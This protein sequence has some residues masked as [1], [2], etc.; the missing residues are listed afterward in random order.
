[1]PRLLFRY[2]AL[3]LVRVIALTTAVL[4][5]VIAFGAAIK[6]LAGN[7]LLDPGQVL[8]Y[9]TL[10]I[11]PMLQF[12]LPFSA[13]FG[14]TL[15]LHRLASD[16]EIQAMALSG[17]SYRRILMPVLALGLGLTLF[18]AVLTQFVIPRFWTAIEGMLAEDAIKL[19][20]SS[21]RRNEPF[22][23]GEDKNLQIYADEIIVDEQ[24]SGADGRD[25]RLILIKVAAAALDEQRRIVRDITANQAIIDVYRIKDRTFLKPVMNE[26]VV[27]E[28]EN[29]TLA[30][31]QRWWVEPLVIPN[32]I[33]T[34]TKTMTQTQLLA[35]RKDPDDFG[36]VMEGKLAL[37]ESL[38]DAEAR[39]VLAGQLRAS[40]RIE[41]EEQV[42]PQAGV[43]RS[44]LVIADRMQK[45]QFTSK[46]GERIE[47]VQMEQ[48]VPALRL[49]VGE[50]VLEPSKDGSLK[51]STFQLTLKDVEVTDLRVGGVPNQRPQVIAANLIIPGVITAD[52]SNLSSAELITQA[53]RYIEHSDSVAHAHSEMHRKVRK[54]NRDINSQILN[55]YAL[56]STAFLLLALGAT[57]AIWLRGSL[58][59]TIYAWSFMPAIFDLILIEAGAQLIR[60]GRIVGHLVMWS[61]NAAILLILFSVYFKLSRN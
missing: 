3:D 52:N 55:R 58:P 40:G 56:S 48:G 36:Y 10:A 39:T 8:R 54:L 15:T 21:I 25:M 37:A 33:K 27:Y 38:R 42:P 59:L 28:A 24:R 29:S 11:V 41:L 17:I 50:A 16:N 7:D 53:Q 46:Q 32:K 20:T 23:F 5:T 9:I 4:V 1:M 47:V 34:L 31:S 2:I 49:R 14:A 26:A 57:L 12:A 61:G 18:M 43:Q 30:Y 35:L 6:P 45:D 60:D 19:L 22:R 51:A 13:G 44:Y